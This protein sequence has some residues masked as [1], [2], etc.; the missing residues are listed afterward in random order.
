MK[1][2]K[3]T[4]KMRLIMPRIGK[5]TKTDLETKKKTIREHP[6]QMPIYIHYDG[7]NYNAIGGLKHSVELPKLNKKYQA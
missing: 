1:E 7:A 4:P 2:F 5:F 6:F 3:K